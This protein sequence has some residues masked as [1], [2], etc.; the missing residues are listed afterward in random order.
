MMVNKQKSPYYVPGEILAVFACFLLFFIAYDV[1]AL[2]HP[3]A[4]STASL[5][6]LLYWE[7]WE[8][9]H[10]YSMFTASSTDLVEQIE[11]DEDETKEDAEL[12]IKVLKAVCVLLLVLFALPIVYVYIMVLMNN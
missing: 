3:I 4:I 8:N 7:I 5:V 12:S 2:S 1:V 6:Y 9:R 11:L 10:H